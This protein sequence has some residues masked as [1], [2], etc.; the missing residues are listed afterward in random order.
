[1]SNRSPLVQ[2]LNNDARKLKN[3]VFSSFGWEY[4]GSFISAASVKCNA[5]FLEAFQDL[6]AY[7]MRVFFVAMLLVS[8]A[9]AFLFPAPANNCCP[10]PPPPPCGCGGK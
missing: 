6:R 1:M 10:P 2:L 4:E 3:F 7:R 9:S 5:A 8:A